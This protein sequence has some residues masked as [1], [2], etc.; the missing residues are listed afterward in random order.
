MKM[1]RCKIYFDIE[2]REK[3]L[4]PKLDSFIKH[5]KMKKRNKVRLGIILK[6][7]FFG[8]SNVHV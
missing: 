5:S 8:P 4:I 7:Y 3:L 6:Q 1:V 2:R